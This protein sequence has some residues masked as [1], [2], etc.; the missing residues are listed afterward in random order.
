MT[1]HE[2]SFVDAFNKIA[3]HKHRYKV[4]AD[5]V[6][7]SAISLHNSIRKSEELEQEY[8]SIIGKYSKEEV[9]KFAQL[10]GEL[11]NLLEAR[12]RDVLGQ[13]YMSLELGNSNSGQFFSP[14]SIS[15]MMA[16]VVSGDHIELPDCGFVTLSEPACGAGGMVLA[17]VDEMLQQ[18]LNP[19]HNLWVQCIDIDRT[20]A[21]M[22][23]IQLSLW[24]VPAQVIVGNSLSLEFREQYFT[25]AHYLFNWDYKLR[26]RRKQRAEEKE[27]IKPETKTKPENPEMPLSEPMTK[28]VEADEIVQ[29]D[30]FE[31]L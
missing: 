14:D 1:L 18:K 27:K 31:N 7:V 24:N 13:L 6:T 20:V 12:P 26:Q 5:F 21:L 9:S 28:I 16:K 25:P 17:Y 2:K 11:V 4:F 30:M 23:Y 10:L 29:L 19:A 22:C 3:R 8:L 15:R